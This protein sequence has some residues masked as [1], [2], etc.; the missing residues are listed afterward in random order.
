MSTFKKVIDD[1]TLASEDYKWLL[2]IAT[3]LLVLSWLYILDIK[4]DKPMPD[5]CFDNFCVF[6]K[7]E[8]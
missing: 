3:I 7:G 2:S 1:E 5:Y 8:K 6:V 4:L